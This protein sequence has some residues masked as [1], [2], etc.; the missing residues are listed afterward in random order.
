MAF[1]RIS[2]D[3]AI[4]ILLAGLALVPMLIGRR[5][6]DR[7]LQVASQSGNSRPRQ[8]LALMLWIYV[9]AFCLT[10]AE[11]VAF[12]YNVYLHPQILPPLGMF[13]RLFLLRALCMAAWFALPACLSILMDNLFLSI[14][15]SAAVTIGLHFLSPY[16]LLSDPTLW[17]DRISVGPLL[18]LIAVCLV[19]IAVWTALG[20]FFYN[21]ADIKH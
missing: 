10:A 13:I 2:Q 9:I 6:D 8:A 17:A 15:F 4:S 16:S 3:S 19:W 1:K 20:C 11:L 5:K 14:V 12:F 18:L 7:S 21:R